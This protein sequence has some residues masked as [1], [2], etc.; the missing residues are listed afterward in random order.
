MFTFVVSCFV[1]SMF[2]QVEVVISDCQ[3]CLKKFTVMEN[4]TE[5]TDQQDL[6][7][8]CHYS[9]ELVA[10]GQNWAVFQH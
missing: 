9:E 1:V 10:I 4:F 7:V 3:K 8:I 6:I 5:S 2:K